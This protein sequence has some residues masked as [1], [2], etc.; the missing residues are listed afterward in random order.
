MS[1]HVRQQA[2]GLQLDQRRRDQ[3]EAGGDVE[4]EVLHPL[5]L[6]EVGVDDRGQVDLVDVDL[7]RRISCRS[8]SNGPS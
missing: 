5:D 6:D 4:V 8:R 2:A 3:Q 7:F 1:R